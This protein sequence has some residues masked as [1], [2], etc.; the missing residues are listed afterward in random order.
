VY[1]CTCVHVLCALHSVLQQNFSF[2]KLAEI[3]EMPYTFFV[4][5]HFFIQEWKNCFDWAEELK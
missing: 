4:C 1:V 2:E 3:G 5:C